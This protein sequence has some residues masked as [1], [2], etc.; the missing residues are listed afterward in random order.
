MLI[1]CLNIYNYVNNDN[2][3]ISLIMNKTDPTFLWEAKCGG[4]QHK[5]RK[6]KS[7]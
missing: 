5:Q 1:V 3:M 4:T 7:L 6:E 2:K